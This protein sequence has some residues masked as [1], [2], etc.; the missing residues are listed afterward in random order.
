MGEGVPADPERA[1][2]L[3]TQAAAFGDTAA[4]EMLGA[5]SLHGTGTPK[6]IPAALRWYTR[7]AE[8]GRVNAQFVLGYLHSSGGEV[9]LDYSLANRWLLKAAV[10]GNAVALV[11]LAAHLDNGQ[12]IK[13]DKLKACGLVRVALKQALPPDIE[14]PMRKQLDREEKTLSPEQLIE[15]SALEMLY[16]SPEGLN[17]LQEDLNSFL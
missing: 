2:E 6:N 4:Y 12:G 10:Q 5:A 11:M 17:G 14:G 8:Q 3:L 16:S 13:R 15:V 9:A 7:A 1:V